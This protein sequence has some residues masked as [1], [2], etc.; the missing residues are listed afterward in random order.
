[1][2]LA[3]FDRPLG[4]PDAHANEAT[5]YTGEDLTQA[6]DEDQEPYAIPR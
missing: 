4:I 6:E 2:I 1:M 3:E 5:E